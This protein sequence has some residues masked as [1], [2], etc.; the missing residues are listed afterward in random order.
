MVFKGRTIRV[1][2][3]VT[4]EP[5]LLAY[6]QFVDCELVGPALIL[7]QGSTTFKACAFI[8]P[9]SDGV[10]RPEA[11]L[12]D[13]PDG[14]TAPA[15][16]VAMFDCHFEGCRFEGVTFCGAENVMNEFRRVGGWPERWT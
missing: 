12:I 8:V 9:Q 1:A 10:L 6:R 2:D 15:G 7:L 5:W 11:I 16:A 4:E 13:L 3:L 14:G